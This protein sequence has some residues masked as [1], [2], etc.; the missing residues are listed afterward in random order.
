MQKRPA[1][2][3]TSSTPRPKQDEAALR[4]AIAYA[5]RAP[6][7]HNTQPWRLRLSADRIE[8]RADESRRLS[9]V[10]PGG[11]ELILSCGALLFS[12]RCAL[13]HGG[14]DVKLETFPEAC[15]PVL[16]AR[17]H[18]QPALAT[19]GEPEL[20]EAIGRRQTHRGPFLPEPLDERLIE[21]LRTAAQAES[22]ALAT[23][24][25]EAARTALAE[26]VAEGDR[27]QWSN[28][29]FR[30]ELAAWMRPNTSTRGDGL[31]GYTL[32]L[33][34]V[35]SRLAPWVVRHLDTGKT[36]ARTDRKLMLD[37]PLLIVL[38]TGGDERADW[39]AAGQALQHVLLRAAAQG[40][41]AGFMNQPL[42]CSSLRPR[43]DARLGSAGHAQVLMRLGRARLG[44]SS[45]RRAWSEVV[46]E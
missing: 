4:Q 3:S 17:I 39:L 5:L 24:T 44:K 14:Y 43:L 19:A 35:L 42:Q 40:V 6:S 38:A 30:E 1:A 32:G 31:A 11:R 2:Q 15:E 27:L 37:A 18:C 33:G 41:S 8:L 34:N 29:H 28:P 45:P 20:F 21:S 10:D 7:S 22:V 46:A 36:Q 16:L 12:L 9:V 26:L 23:F 25:D 13:E